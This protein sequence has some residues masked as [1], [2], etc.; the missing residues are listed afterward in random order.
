MIKFKKEPL[1]ER[2]GIKYFSLPDF[3]T[4]NYE[5]I[6]ADH[7]SHFTK[8]ESN[9]F[10]EETLWQESEEATVA[11]VKKHLKPG[12]KVLD[13]GVG[14]GRLLEKLPVDIEKYGID[15]SEGYLNIAKDKQI[16]CFYSK[17]EDMPFE[18]ESFDLIVCT[19]V[20]EH[21]FDLYDCS[22]K[23]INCL[24]K[25]GTFIVRVPYK[26][27]LEG[28]M[29]PAYPYEYVHLRNF[30][31]NNLKIFFTKIFKLKFLSWSTCGTYIHSS[32]FKWSEIPNDSKL[33]K[34]ANYFI[35]KFLSRVQKV[36][37]GY[38]RDLFEKVE[39]LITFKK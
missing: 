5:K 29:D 1:K 10:I 2:D 27:N 30:D 33:L 6:S 39:I 28:Y 24:K 16:T 7:I 36:N 13:V 9:P 31:E 8:T 35:K 34:A 3:Y 37:P 18:D 22:A 32:R 21:V 15:I 20:L 12:F 17:I 26:E 38:Y 4:E 14:L 25:D 11:E 23:I 19:D